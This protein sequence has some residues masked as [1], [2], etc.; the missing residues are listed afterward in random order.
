MYECFNG[1]YGGNMANR[2][3]KRLYRR[4]QSGGLK[5]FLVAGVAVLVTGLLIA[6]GNTGRTQA[7]AIGK[8]VYQTGVTPEGEP[9]KGSPDAPLQLVEYSDFLCSHCANFATALSTLSADYIETGK[10]QVVYR[11]F[12]F[13]APE[14]LQAAQATECALDQSP[15]AFWQYHDLLF[16]NQASNRAAFSNSQLKRYAG[17]VG[18]DAAAFNACLDSNVKAG[19][20]QSDLD[21]GESL[22]VEATPTWFIN[23]QIVRGELPESELRQMFD[24]LLSQE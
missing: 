23:G 14:S 2:Q 9:Y 24:R 8:P 21:K 6:W 12:A 11:N 20:I 4:R 7:V 16:A 3:K 18:L 5:I 19:E 13:L 17:Q 22:G 10:L 1:I 15:D